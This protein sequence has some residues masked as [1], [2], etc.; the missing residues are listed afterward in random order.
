M[1]GAQLDDDDR[2]GLRINSQQN[3]GTATVLAGLF[4]A[5]AKESPFKEFVDDIG[6][7]RLRH[8]GDFG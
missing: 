5:L 1:E 3:P 4:S 2:C 6:N 8:A 7:A